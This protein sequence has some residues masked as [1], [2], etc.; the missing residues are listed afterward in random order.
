MVQDQSHG[1]GPMDDTIQ[2]DPEFLTIEQVASKIGCSIRRV[3]LMR[4][5]GH[6]P[7]AL[8]I[9]PL[10]RWRRSSLEQWLQQCETT[11]PKS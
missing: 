11:Q 3:Y 6:I 9:G 2:F 10:I 1:D 8:K 4:D 5:A 7:Q